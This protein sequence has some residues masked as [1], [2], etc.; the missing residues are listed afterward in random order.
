[1]QARIHSLKQAKNLFEKLAKVEECSLIAKEQVK[2]PNIEPC[3]ET[4]RELIMKV[5]EIEQ[6]QEG[7]TINNGHGGAKLASAKFVVELAR[8]TQKDLT[9]ALDA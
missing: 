8:L 5:T 4:Y 1:M 2:L 6:E 3:L 9:K 7:A